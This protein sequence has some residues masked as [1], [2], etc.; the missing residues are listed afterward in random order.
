[1]KD[2]IKPIIKIQ[3]TNALISNQGYTYNEPFKT[4]NEIGLMYCG[5]YG[6]DNIP[7]F[8]HSLAVSPI[9]KPIKNDKSNIIVQKTKK[10]ISSQ[11]FTYNESGKSYN[12]LGMMYGGIY[13]FDIAPIL[14]MVKAFYPSITLGMDFNSQAPISPPSGMS[15][16]SIG[17]LLALTYSSW[18]NK[19]LL[20]R[21]P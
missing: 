18:Y 2:L 10:D 15:G 14:N 4:Y 16:M 12:E 19:L 8:S 3:N 11:L 5:L 6:H 1:M 7:Q 17:L 13:G 9:F 20:T 21:E